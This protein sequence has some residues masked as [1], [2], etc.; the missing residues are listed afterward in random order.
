MYFVLYLEIAGSFVQTKCVINTLA[1][2]FWNEI[3]ASSLHIRSVMRSVGR[4]IRRNA[5]VFL[6]ALIFAYVLFEVGMLYQEKQN[7][8]RQEQERNKG[9]MKTH[10]KE[11]VRDISKKRDIVLKSLN[12]KLKD[13]TERKSNDA[14][15]LIGKLTSSPEKKTAEGRRVERSDVL[16]I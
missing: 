11:S 14:M 6:L 8:K 5:C 2:L 7:E 10:R 15:I 16:I 3:P 1:C 4:K 13:V 12:D 9:S